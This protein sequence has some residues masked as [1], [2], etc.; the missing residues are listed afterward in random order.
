M[1]MKTLVS[2]ACC[3]ISGAVSAQNNPDR[4]FCNGKF[5]TVDQKFSIAS[6]ISIRD[7][8][9]VAVGDTA[10]NRKLAGTSTVQT[11]LGGRSYW[12]QTGLMRAN[13][14][15]SPQVISAQGMCELRTASMELGIT[16]TMSP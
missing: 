15:M 3:M 1:S 9:I 7:E 14:N 4:I 11:D 13:P 2:L 12:H 8:R 5:L 6:A 16:G 10:T